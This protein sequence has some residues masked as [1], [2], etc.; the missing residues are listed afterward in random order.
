MLKIT[1]KADYGIIALSHLAGCSESSVSCREIAK[2][3]GIPLHLLSNILKTL[4]HHGIVES[5]RGANGGYRLAVKPEEVSLGRLLE[6]LEGPIRLTECMELEAG[7]SSDCKLEASCPV[8]APMKKLHDKFKEWLEEVTFADLTSDSDS[9][10]EG[11]KQLY[12]I[13]GLYG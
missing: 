5:V 3:S 6:I 11:G 8:R 13:A 10:N 1:K 4:S 9:P 12:E 7:S 2:R